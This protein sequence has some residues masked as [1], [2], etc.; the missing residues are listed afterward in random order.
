M[1]VCIQP[2][3]LYIY[4]NMDHE[5]LYRTSHRYIRHSVLPVQIILCSHNTKDLI[6]IQDAA[7][8]ASDRHTLSS[9]FQSTHQRFVCV[10]MCLWI[11]PPC[12]SQ[13]IVVVH[14]LY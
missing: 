13:T 1:Y 6:G 4:N 3:V 12:L 8:E 10:C 7:N 11:D 14:V 9:L 5:G 2:V